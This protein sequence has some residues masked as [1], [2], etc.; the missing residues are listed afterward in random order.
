MLLEIIT[1]SFQRG[2]SFT[3]DLVEPN[4]DQR[5]FEGH[6]SRAIKRCDSKKMGKHLEL[7]IL[8]YPACNSLKRMTIYGDLNV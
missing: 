5:V 6:L 2:F 3:A 7:I 8:P 1:V 4:Q